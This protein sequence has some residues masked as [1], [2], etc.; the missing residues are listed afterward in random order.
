VNTAQSAA[1]DPQSA[2]P[3]RQSAVAKSAIG[4]RQSPIDKR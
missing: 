3:N 4:N 1:D 2:I